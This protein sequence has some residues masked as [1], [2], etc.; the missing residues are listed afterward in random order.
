[1]RGRVFA[2]EI[3]SGG[4]AMPKRQCRRCEETLRPGDY[5]PE[6][7]LCGTCVYELRDAIMHECQ[8][9]GLT[10]CDDELAEIEDYFQRVGPGDLAPSGECPDRECGALCFP[11]QGVGEEIPT[12]KPKP[13]TSNLVR[14]RLNLEYIVDGDNPEM[15]RAALTALYEDLLNAGKYDELAD[16]LVVEDAPD[17]TEADIPEF[18]LE[19]AREEEDGAEEE[20]EAPHV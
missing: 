4:G 13:P 8:G 17:A 11:V 16:C 10:W 14:V 7:T 6:E 18:L 2:A 20:E 19:Y 15:V 12:P 9:C 3:R 1:M 5:T